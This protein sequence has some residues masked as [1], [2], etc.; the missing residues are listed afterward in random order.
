MGG[1][2]RFEDRHGH[3]LNKQDYDPAPYIGLRFEGGF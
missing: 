1:E 3:R 2:V